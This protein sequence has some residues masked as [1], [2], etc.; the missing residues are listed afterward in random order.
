LVAEQPFLDE[1]EQTSMRL[2]IQ[3]QQFQYYYYT[4]LLIRSRPALQEACISSAQQALFSLEDLVSDSSE[5]Y[6]GVIW[7][8]LYCPFTPFF[9]LFGQIISTGSNSSSRQS[10]KAMESM[11]SFL[12]QMESRHPQAAKLRTIAVTFVQYAQQIFARPSTTTPERVHAARTESTPSL[13]SGVM[14]AD[15]T[16]DA[17]LTLNPLQAHNTHQQ[18]SQPLLDLFNDPAMQDLSMDMD[19]WLPNNDAAFQSDALSDGMGGT[20][21]GGRTNNDAYGFFADSN[22]DWLSWDSMT[23]MTMQ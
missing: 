1:E 19:F 11:S 5:V 9:I 10:L 6:N 21:A 3:Y 15:T 7:V 20:L 18:H 4:V 17:L 8:L 16:P 14:T 22:F 23:D 2:G 12:Q 13:S